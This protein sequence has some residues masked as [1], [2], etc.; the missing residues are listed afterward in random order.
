MLPTQSTS[1]STVDLVNPSP[2]LT[3]EPRDFYERVL[4]NMLDEW[5]AAPLAGGHPLSLARWMDTPFE[6]KDAGDQRREEVICEAWVDLLRLHGSAQALGPDGDGLIICG[7]MLNR[8]WVRSL[9]TEESAYG[10]ITLL[11]RFLDHY[12][13]RPDVALTKDIQASEA[14]RAM[15]N[16]WLAPGYRARPHNSRAFARALFGETWCDL[17]FD[18]KDPKT[19]LETLINMTRPPFVPGLLPQ[20][21]TRVVE[22][23]PA[24]E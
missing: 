22:S 4:V 12:A 13:I 10:F 11:S 19:S 18:T 9:E 15:L 17:V 1:A 2:R 14:A 23:L 21:F 5:R 8:R 3:L 6:L 7:L 20:D 16:A 24:L